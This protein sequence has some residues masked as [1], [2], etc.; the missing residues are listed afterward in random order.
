VVD[1]KPTTL[2]CGQNRAGEARHATGN[3][4]VASPIRNC[5]LRCRNHAPVIIPPPRS[6]D[7]PCHRTSAGMNPS[8]EFS[9]ISALRSICL[10]EDSG[11]GVVHRRAPAMAPPLCLGA[12]PPCVLV[13]GET[14]VGQGET[15]AGCWM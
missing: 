11:I 2:S 4:I 6:V 12:P 9:I 5:A 3:T 14:R 8:I 10:I 1:L 13:R 7:R 15:Y